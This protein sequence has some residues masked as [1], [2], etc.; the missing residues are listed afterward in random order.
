MAS[1]VHNGS[2]FQLEFGLCAGGGCEGK[3]DGLGSD[4]PRKPGQSGD[5]S[6]THG[7]EAGRVCKT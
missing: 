2:S 3:L 7:T 4:G 6:Y 1:S 5:T